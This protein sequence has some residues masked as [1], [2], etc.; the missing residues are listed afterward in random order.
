MPGI[1][2]IYIIQSCKFPMRIYV[3]SAVNIRG[4]WSRHLSD[5]RKN[6][7]PNPKL[8]NHYN[9]YGEND[10]AFEI[11]ENGE[12]LCKQ[13]LHAREQ[14]WIYHYKHKETWVPYFNF[15]PIAGSPLGIKRTAEQ[16]KHVYGNTYRKGAV[17]SEA[18]KQLLRLANLGKKAS[19]ETKE[20]MRKTS[21]ALGRKPPIQFKKGNVPWN[22]GLKGRESWNK[23]LKNPEGIKGKISKLKIALK[24]VPA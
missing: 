8:Q 23:G 11:I 15:T 2:G 7:H 22:K 16:L 17:L 6:R 21:L 10:L 4:R 1:G 12:Y 9:K 5:L 18:T 24:C 19:P 3:G 20:K 14:G 13:H